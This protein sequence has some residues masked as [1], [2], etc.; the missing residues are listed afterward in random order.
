MILSASLLHAASSAEAAHE[1]LSRAETHL[2]VLLEKCIDTVPQLLT[3]ASVLL[4][5]AR[6]AVWADPSE[7]L[8]DI[9]SWQPPPLLVDTMAHEEQEQEPTENVSKD[10]L[11]V[12]VHLCDHLFQQYDDTP[13][14]LRMSVVYSD[15]SGERGFMGLGQGWR[16]SEDANRISLKFFQAYKMVGRGKSV[17]DALRK[18]V[19][20][21]VTKKMVALFVESTCTSEIDED[22]DEEGGG[23]ALPMSPLHVLRRA[24][25]KAF[26]AEEWVM[27]GVMA[28]RVVDAIDEK[29]EME[30]F[31]QQ[32]MQWVALHQDAL[33]EPHHVTACVDYMVE[34]RRIEENYEC[35]GRTPKKVLESLE[36]YELS[37]LSFEGDEAF[38]RNPVGI[39]GMILED[40]SVPSGTKVYVPYEGLFEFEQESVPMTVRVAE[41]LSLQRLVYEG[42]ALGNCLRDNRRSQVKYVSRVRQRMSSFWS[43][44]FVIGGDVHF[45]CLVEV[46]HL[47]RGNIIH[48]AEG[49]RPRTIPS[50]MAWHF[51]EKWCDKQ[52][53][54]LTEWECYS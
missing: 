19:T 21:A 28:S 20:A 13:D 46:W 18:H 47:R 6:V 27:Q 37:T 31:V 42:T 5:L 25:L 4:P 15:A 2:V 40:T 14:A 1:A 10:A 24:Q 11:D 16:C 36:A 23:S 33:A 17:R 9:T 12:V 51:L 22:G 45:Q 54:D 43:M 8:R 41:I 34:M 30:E 29:D 50:P 7:Y 32:T 26:D 3:H 52:K 48:Q 39:E 35:F 44:T 53:L 38:E 49:P